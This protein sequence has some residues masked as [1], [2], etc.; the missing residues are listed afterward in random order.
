MICL[1][2]KNKQGDSYMNNVKRLFFIFT[3]FFFTQSIFLIAMESMEPHNKKKQ[4]QQWV[5]F[6]Q[7]QQL[8][9]PDKLGKGW[10]RY[11]SQQSKDKIVQAGF[12]LLRDIETDYGTIDQ[13]IKNSVFD[14]IR[15]AIV[16]YAKTKTYFPDWF[17]INGDIAEITSEIESLITHDE[18]LPYIEPTILNQL[19]LPNTTAKQQR[20]KQAIEQEKQHNLELLKQ[21]NIVVEQLKSQIQQNKLRESSRE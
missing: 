5:K 4:I 15:Q 13:S 8:L 7:L 10:F 1:S 20:Y 17:M 6:E 2:L 12:E 21:K 19:L 18:S 14:T 16:H 3:V 9:Q 11:P